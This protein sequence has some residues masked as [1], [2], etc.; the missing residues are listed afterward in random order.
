MS[1]SKPSNSRNRRAVTALIV[2]PL[3]IGVWHSTNAQSHGGL[4]TYV[5]KAGDVFISEQ[6]FIQRF[7]MLP[8]LYRH[9]TSH[10]DGAKL[11]LLYSIIAEK[12]LAQEAL[13]RRFD[14]DSI[15][16]LAFTEV[17]RLLARDELYR[18]EVSNK[19]YITPAEI[20]KEMARAQLQVLVAFIFF[21]REDDA[22]FVRERMKNVS[23]F[24][25]LQIDSSMGAMRDTATVIWSDAD[26]DIE[27][28]AYKLKQGEISPVVEA[29]QGF[30][31]LKRLNATPSGLYASM[32]PNI[33]RERVTTKIRTRKEQSRAAVFVDEVLNDKTGRS[34]SGPFKLLGKS[35]A[36]VFQGHMRDS[37]ITLTHDLANELKG[38]IGQAVADILVEVG[39]TR[40]TID[41]IIER[42]LSKQ[43]SIAGTDLRRLPS[44]LNAE[45]KLMVQQELLGQEALKRGLD[46]AQGVRQQLEMWHNAYLADMMK[47]YVGRNVKISD[48]EVYAYL[49]LKDTASIVPRVQIRE[50]RTGSISEMNEAL[51]D[52]EGG[53]SLKQ[54]IQRWSNDT[55]VRTNEGV[56]DLF[57]IT[58]RSPIGEIA[59]QMEI[60]QRYGPVQVPQGVLYFEL[61]ARQPVAG[62]PTDT[63][64]EERKTSARED[65][66]RMKQ[67]RTLDLF[68]AQIGQERGFMVFEDR[69]KKVEASP[70]PMMTFRLLGFGG[71]MFAVPFVQK[72]LDWLG[73]DPPQEKILP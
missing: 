21:D 16:Q 50:L 64:L 48:A 19:V 30:Y 56:S 66:L 47:S 27:A 10:L 61:L 3:L 2:L 32:Q 9:R 37:L 14:Q 1:K 38:R 4:D 70:I 24:D 60:G 40:W 15:V 44:R 35:M 69:L 42:L 39:D 65:L 41:E 71:R 31:I 59:S 17:R 29:G 46:N 53:M 6:E 22:R 49:K 36:D 57:P 5:G 11:E 8:S 52:L 72:Q 34:L 55:L 54:T 33:L 7:E 62:Q 13:A 63:T 58:D 12:L 23:D 67:K 28:A 25:L 43:F 26:P 45:I 20:T 51:S 18:Q 68:L 73:I